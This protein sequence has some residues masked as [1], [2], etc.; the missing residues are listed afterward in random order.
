MIDPSVLAAYLLLSISLALIPGPDVMCILGHAIPHGSTSGLKVCAG[1]TLAMLI[2][3]TAA[4]LGLTTFLAAAPAAY[5][6]VKTAGAAYLIWLGWQMLR[7]PASRD[8][9]TPAIYL[10][11]PFVQGMIANL[12][13][14]KIAIFF[15]AILPQFLDPA[16]GSTALQAAALGTSSVIITGLVNLCVAILGGKAQKLLQS[17]PIA[18]RRVRQATGS[19]LIGLSL[20]VAFE[21]TPC[22][23][24]PITPPRPSQ[25]ALNKSNAVK[26]NGLT[27]LPLCHWRPVQPLVRGGASQSIE[28]G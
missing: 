25:T 26:L 21:R 20:K 17:K 22:V 23:S 27:V 19:L 7:R 24:T 12:L 10:R 5:I 14:P 3:V 9:K 2:H 4:T 1:M 11:S 15:L 6:I 8:T 18:F 13:N 28:T 16:R